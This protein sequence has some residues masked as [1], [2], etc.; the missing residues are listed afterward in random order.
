MRFRSTDKLKIED[1]WVNFYL[2]GTW[3][4]EREHHVYLDEVV[5]ADRYIG[6]LRNR[7]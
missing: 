6:P 2:G 5:I 3:T 1:V 7:P 4:A